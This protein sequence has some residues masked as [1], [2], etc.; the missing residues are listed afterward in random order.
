M[1]TATPHPHTPV[2]ALDR[3]TGAALPAASW[4]PLHPAAV[5]AII[6]ANPIAIHFF[7]FILISSQFFI[8]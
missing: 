4:L 7:A 5:S 1:T 2:G 3:S 8:Y 6:P